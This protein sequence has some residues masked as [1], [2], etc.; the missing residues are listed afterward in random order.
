MNFR[1]CDLVGD[2]MWRHEGVCTTDTLVSNLILKEYWNMSVVSWS[3][4]SPS[5][6]SRPPRGIHCVYS[7]V[8]RVLS[9][10]VATQLR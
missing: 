4:H 2:L 8:N 1:E 3:H 10:S 6:Q 5:F 9:G 7:V